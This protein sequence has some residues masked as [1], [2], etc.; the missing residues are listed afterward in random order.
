MRS[1][2]GDYSDGVTGAL[3][4]F[5]FIVASTYLVVMTQVMPFALSLGLTRRHF[6]TGTALLV[7]VET[8]FNAVVLTGLLQIEQWTGG[9]GMNVE[10]FGMGFMVQSNLFLQV[11]AYWVPLFTLAFVFLAIG[12]VFRR[13]GQPGVWTVMIGIVLVLAG[14]VMYFTWQD[15]WAAFARFFVETPTGG[16]EINLA[17]AGVTLTGWLTQVQSDGLL[18]WRP[19]VPLG[20]P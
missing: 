9:W 6:Y 13:W 14:L 11:L 7:A 4:S 20:K 19:G 5:F 18:R 17:L 2:T 16:W 15:A 8:L 3:T 10:F 1:S 12:A